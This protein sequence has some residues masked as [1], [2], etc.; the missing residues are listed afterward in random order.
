MAKALSKIQDSN[1]VNRFVIIYVDDIM[2][3]GNYLS[4]ITILKTSL[5]DRFKIK[6]LRTMM[7]FLSLEV[8]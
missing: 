3:V 1:E 2:V 7:F 8:A 6:D 4:A 5:D